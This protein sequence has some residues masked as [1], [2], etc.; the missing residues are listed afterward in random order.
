MNPLP[1]FSLLVLAALCCVTG[2]AF[3][4]PIDYNEVSLLVRAREPQRSI[5]EEVSRRKLVR[6]LTPQ[7]EQTLKSQG[8]SDSLLQ[9]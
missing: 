8:A 5:T 4:E 3:A 9:A 2:G 1:R 7:Q 6:A